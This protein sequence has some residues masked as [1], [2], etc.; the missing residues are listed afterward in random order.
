[1]AL[2]RIQKIILEAL[3]DSPLRECFYWTGG[4]LLAERYLQHRKSFDVDLFTDKPFRYEEVLPF[5]RQIKR[6]TKLAVVEQQKVHDRWEFFIHNHEE[7]RF[8]F[9]HY[10]FP[11]L[12]SRARW[13]GVLV[14]SLDDLAANK[15]MALIER[16]EPKDV[17]DVYFL[18]TKA[19][20]QPSRLLKL[21]HKKFG[22]RIDDTTLLGEILH[23][24]KRLSE[25]KTMLHGTSREQ[26]ATLTAIQ[27]YFK[28]MSVKHLRKRLR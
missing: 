23:G 22:L 4:T 24:A 9:V 10:D 17:V 13:Q 18:I 16:H 28:T 14:D 7:V 3:A 15:T 26:S 27:D 1:M 21:A 11:T 2:G 25:I 12:K 5:V 19:G 8:E 20:F 6:R